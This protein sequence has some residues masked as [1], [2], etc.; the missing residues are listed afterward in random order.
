MAKSQK[1]D[2]NGGSDNALSSG[3]RKKAATLVQALI[4]EGE[5]PPVLSPSTMWDPWA[6]ATWYGNCRTLSALL[7]K[8]NPWAS[9]LCSWDSTKGDDRAFHISMLGTLRSIAQYL[10]V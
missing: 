5:N 4:N 7:G 6:L 10:G 8:D 3:D 2:S 1:D 9:V